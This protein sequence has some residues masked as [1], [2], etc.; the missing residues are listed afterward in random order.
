MSDRT[1]RATLA[2]SALLACA[3][4]AYLVVVHYRADALV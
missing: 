2:S 3:I 4:A 1:V